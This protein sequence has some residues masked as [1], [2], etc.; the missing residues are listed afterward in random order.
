MP[1]IA[2][3][4]CIATRWPP[5]SRACAAI[6][7][8]RRRWLKAAAI[9]VGVLL[10]CGVHRLQAGRYFMVPD[11]LSAFLE[12]AR[13]QLSGVFGSH[14][15]QWDQQSDEWIFSAPLM[16]TSSASQDYLFPLYAAEFVGLASFGALVFGIV[17][18]VAVRRPRLTATVAT[19]CRVGLDAV[20]LPLVRDLA[21]RRPEPDDVARPSGADD[22]DRRSVDRAPDARSRVDAARPSRSCWPP[23][24][25]PSRPSAA[26]P[27]S[28]SRCS[29]RVSGTSCVGAA[30]SACARL[31]A[32]C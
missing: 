17:H 5:A 21:D 30:R 12:A 16:F 29:A 13:Q 25:W 7:S 23:R 3:R 24:A 8:Y 1:A 4:C 19:G 6:L 2:D 32:P 11:S 9:V 26:R 18:S 10:L 20:D 14:L 22:R 27:T 28:S 15:A 31:R